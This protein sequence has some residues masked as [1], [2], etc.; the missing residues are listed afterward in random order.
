ML[1]GL[2]HH[3]ERGYLYKSVTVRTF[4]NSGLIRSLSVNMSEPQATADAEAPKKSAAQLKKEA[5]KKEKL[6]K[7]EAKMKAM[8]A[9]KAAAADVSDARLL[10]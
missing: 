10:E 1:I 9:S 6:E 8:E 4:V 2:F 3:L 5:R 7:Y